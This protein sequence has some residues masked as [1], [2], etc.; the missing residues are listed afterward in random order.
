MNSSLIIQKN[1][2]QLLAQKFGSFCSGTGPKKSF[3]RI[4]IVGNNDKEFAFSYFI[5]KFDV[6]TLH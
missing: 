5:I 3:F 4:Q 2:L 1:G 6:I